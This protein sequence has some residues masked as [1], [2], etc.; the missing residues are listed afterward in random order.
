MINEYDFYWEIIDLFNYSYYDWKPILVLVLIHNLPT[1]LVI[2]DDISQTNDWKDFPYS[3]RVLNYS[4][5]SNKLFDVMAISLSH[6][7]LLD[8]D[9]FFFLFSSFCWE[10]KRHRRIPAV[11]CIKLK[12]K[13]HAQLPLEKWQRSCRVPRSN[14][15]WRKCY[16]FFFLPDE[17][18]F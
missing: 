5:I 15:W 4:S 6:F 7:P 3:D 16:Q 12:L 14:F 9:L 8:I 1:S 2:S 11:S 18:T 10:G 13:E 17:R